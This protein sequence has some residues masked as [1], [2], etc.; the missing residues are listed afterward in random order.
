M[1]RP[2]LSL[3]F[4]IDGSAWHVSTIF[5]EITKQKFKPNEFLFGLFLHGQFLMSPIT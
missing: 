4:F 3:I 2:P 1:E 5:L